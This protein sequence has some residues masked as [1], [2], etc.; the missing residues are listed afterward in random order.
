MEEHRRNVETILNALSANQLYC[1]L[2]KTDLFCVDLT[3]LGH[4]ISRNGITPDG[5]KV[6]KILSWPTPRSAQD[7]R[8]FLGLV[9]YIANFLPRL[10]HH[11]SVLNP[12]TSKEAD[13]SFAWTSQ[14]ERAFDAIKQLVVSHECL[15]SIDHSNLGDNR[16]FVSTDASDYCTGA[17]LSYGPDLQSARPVAFESAQLSGAELNY[18]VHEKEL[19]AIVRALKKWRIDLLGVPFTVFT[20]HRTLENF[21]HQKHLSRRQARWQEF[22]GQYDFRIVY[23]K[24]ADNSVADALSRLPPASSPNVSP[25]DPFVPTPP[26]DDRDP[27]PL[28]IGALRLLR[29]ASHSLVRRRSF[30]CPP[31]P[32]VCSVRSLSVASDPAWLE[33]IRAGY[34]SD[35][36]CLRLLRS[37][38]A[39]GADPLSSL[40]CGSLDGLSLAGVSVRDGLLFVGD[41]LC[42]PRVPELREALY[43]LCH[44]SMGHFGTD[45]SYALLRSSYYWPHMRRDLERLYVPSCEAC[46]RNKSPTQ[47]PRGPLHPLPVP[48]GRLQCIAIDF[49]GRLPEDNGF[50]CICTITCRLGSELR[51]FPCRYDM[52]AEE[53]AELFFVHWYCENGLPIDIVTD[54][55][56]LFVS[57]FWKALHRLTGVDL[58]MSTSF[59]PETDGSSERTNRTV[60]QMLR[61]HVERN[62]SG[63]SRALPLIRFQL[64]CTPNASTGFAPFQLRLG[65]LPR[66]IPPLLSCNADSSISDFGGDGERA[67]ALIA[68]IETDT[69]EAQDNLLLA[70][71][72]QALAANTHRGPELRYSVGDQVLLSTFH[73]RRE[74]MQRGDHRVAKFMVRF[75]GPFTV[76]AA[77]PDSSTYTLDLPRSTSIH[78]TFHASLLRP[79]LPNDD[80]LFPSRA[81]PRPGPIVT[82]DGQQEYFVDRILDRRRRGR[83]WQYLIRWRGYGPGD[84]SWLPGS[85]VQDLEALDVFLQENNLS[86]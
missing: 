67:A 3:F 33:R 79:F 42:V 53:F 17:V 47:K 16:I 46:Q 25:P 80:S 26:T 2:K 44:D 78:P 39:D 81:H 63:W 54:R 15:T 24:G 14:H 62:Q 73:R 19:L 84:D 20:D 5:S 23:L 85:E 74:Y 30:P 64:M 12:L 77:H 72:H 48:D 45:K 59:H 57:A 9:R 6:E 75:D 27:L 11:T 35:R 60:I 40:S 55:D 49:I 65:T 58:K 50:D 71:T 22:L 37:L 29:R 52:S 31:S 38:C 8:S 83:G 69:L 4:R 66:V 61:Y 36:W 70:K 32:P 41:R 18:P 82:P 34:A 1:S 68:R 10:A 76:V 7:V 56:K 86:E 28:P 13:L 43:R 51:V 21:N